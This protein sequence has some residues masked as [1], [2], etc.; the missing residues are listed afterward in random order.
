M[1]RIFRILLIILILTSV[2]KS[3]IIEKL[4][5]IPLTKFDLLVKN[6]SDS[7]NKNL[8][9]YLN[10][11]DGFRVKLDNMKLDFYFDEELQLFIINIYARVDQIR[12]QEKKIIIKKKDCNIIR[13]KIFTKRYGYGM[14]FSKKPTE[15]FNK[16]YIINNSIFLLNNNGLSI[17]DK[18]KIIK[19][20]F[21]SIELDH[22]FGNQKITCKGPLYQVPLK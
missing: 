22:P 6:Y 13:N 3:E 2:A 16:D 7:I 21:I 4:K 12:Y 10:Q 17:D 1:I 15:Y 11:I 19:K 8:S 20:S 14:L 9:K 18:K 5:N